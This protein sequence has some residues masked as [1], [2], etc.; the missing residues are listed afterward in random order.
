MRPRPRV[1]ASAGWAANRMRPSR[2]RLIFAAERP[3]R[4]DTVS[5]MPT[6]VLLIDDE[7]TVTKVCGEMLESAGYEVRVENDSRKGVQV[8]REFRPDVAVV[9]FRM[10]GLSGADL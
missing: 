3:P 7:A 5:P 1:D 8:A 6:R 4:H 2:R 9:D 10:P